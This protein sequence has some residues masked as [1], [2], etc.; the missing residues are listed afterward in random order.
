M[1]MKCENPAPFRETGVSTERGA[2]LVDRRSDVVDQF[3]VLRGEVVHP[4]GGVDDCEVLLATCF[5]RSDERNRVQHVRLAVETLV[6]G[7][8]AV[9]VVTDPDGAALYRV[10]SE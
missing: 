5:V 2:G 7:L 4:P 1:V 9:R 6:T 3:E 8:T 10:E